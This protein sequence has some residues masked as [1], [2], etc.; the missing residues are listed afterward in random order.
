MAIAGKVIVPWISPN[1]T[2]QS[3]DDAVISCIWGERE[4]VID[5]RR[6]L[7]VRVGEAYTAVVESDLYRQV[8]MY[9]ATG[10]TTV[11]PIGQEYI[12][13]QRNCCKKQF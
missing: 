8:G 12:F 1:L 5:I 2:F 3:R 6:L 4:S 9:Q 11:L 7:S 10:C 13:W